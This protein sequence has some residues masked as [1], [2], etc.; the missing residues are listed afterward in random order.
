MYGKI[1]I[2][3]MAL[4]L[5]V[6]NV[7]HAET[8]MERFVASGAIDPDA[9]AVLVTDLADGRRI[10][11]HN[12]ANPLVPASIMKVVTIGT[13]IGETGTDYRYDTEVWIDGAVKDNVLQGNLIV[14]GSGDPSL[15]SRKGP[16]AGDFVTECADA[17]VS[18]GIRS[19]E[20]RIVIDGNIFTDPACPPSWASGDLSQSYGTGCFGFNFENNASGKAAVKNPAFVFEQRLRAELTKRGVTIT[21][22]ETGRGER[23]LLVRHR[24]ATIDEIMRSCMMRSDN[25]F[26]EALLRTY[27]LERGSKG[28]TSKGASLELDHWRRSKAPTEGVKIVDGSGLSRSNRMTADFMTH[29]LTAKSD[30]PYFASFFPL[31]GQEGTLR[32]FM[33]GSELDSYIA[34]KTGSMRGI[35]CYAGYKLDDDYVPTHSVVIMINNMSDRGAARKAVA[36]L[37]LDIFAPGEDGTSVSDE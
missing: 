26:A 1:T 20:G 13:L 21:D 2:I 18:R 37:L 3:I 10:A 5:S 34:L 24:S 30:D 36:R 11:A 28:D 15:N 9:V 32:S 19:I 31:A 8:P 14:V 17:I 35:Q 25:L 7:S 4:L 29:V 22:A 33:H 23:R 6:A 12:S 16:E 27:A